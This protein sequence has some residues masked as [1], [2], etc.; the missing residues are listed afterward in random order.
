[1]SAT[2]NAVKV[3]LGAALGAGIGYVAARLLDNQGAATEASL[4]G[5]TSQPRE[6]APRETF[7][8]RLE[9]ARANGE[10][11]R[12]AKEAEL[13]AYFRVKTNDPEAMTNNPQP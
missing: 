11:A 3:V 4:A 5:T 8:Q 2:R 12:A 13:K 1:M 7:K 10:A 6:T 9:R